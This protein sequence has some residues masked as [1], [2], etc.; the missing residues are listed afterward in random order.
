MA[1]P[2]MPRGRTSSRTRTTSVPRNVTPPPGQLLVTPD[3]MQMSFQTEAFEGAA[4]FA[5]AELGF[6]SQ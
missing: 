3:P 4:T 5:L 6:I 2:P 1:T